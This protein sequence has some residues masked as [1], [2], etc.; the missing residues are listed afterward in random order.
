MTEKPKLISVCIDSGA[1]VAVWPP[2]VAPETPTEESEEIRSGV[3][4]LGPRHKNSP[5][6]A[7]TTSAGGT[8][9][10]SPLPRSATVQVSTFD[11]DP[12]G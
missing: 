4:Y 5:T 3:K 11:E 8:Q 12:F 6:L 7:S 2:E 1:E 9:S 10:R